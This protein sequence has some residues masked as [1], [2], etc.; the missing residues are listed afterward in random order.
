MAKDPRIYPGL[1]YFM[2]LTVAGWTD[3]FIRQYYR[4]LVTEN[5]QFNIQQKGLEVYAFCLMT[6]HMH[7]I[8]SCKEG[9]DLGKM[10]RGFK[11]YTGKLLLEAI[12]NN[13]KESRKEWLMSRFSFLGRTIARDTQRQFW[14][15]DSYPV[16][17]DS[18]KFFQEKKAYIELNPVRAGLVLRAED[19]AHSSACPNCPIDIIRF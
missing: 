19:W 14:D 17:I 15:R 5:L 11:S 4:N 1:T 8:V 16:R 10:I 3:V 6:N 18:D 13:P 12:E 2:T 9:I 7:M